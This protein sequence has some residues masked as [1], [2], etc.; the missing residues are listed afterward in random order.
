MRSPSR[1][2]IK[3]CLLPTGTIVENQAVEGKTI[4]A[5]SDSCHR[6]GYAFLNG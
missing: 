2:A 3:K 1:N 5:N 6:L 4:W